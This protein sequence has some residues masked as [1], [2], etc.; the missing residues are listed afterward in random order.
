MDGIST[1][2]IPGLLLL[3]GLPTLIAGVPVIW[4]VRHRAS[5]IRVTRRFRL[6]RFTLL[7]GIFSCWAV[8]SGLEHRWTGTAIAAAG[9]LYFLWYS[10]R[11]PRRPLTT[12]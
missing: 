7:A 6:N 2:D 9:A 12:A 4:S 11:I 3:F 10:R 1:S 8:E 5:F